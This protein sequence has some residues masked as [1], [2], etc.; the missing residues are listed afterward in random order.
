M[1]YTGTEMPT[2]ARP[3]AAWSQP[4]PRLMRR[5]RTERQ[6][7]QQ[8][9]QQRE[10]ADREIDRQPLR[11][12]LV[13][14]AVAVLERRA[15]IAPRELREITDVLFPHRLVEVV[16]A[17]D[18]LAHLRHQLL[19]GVER[20]AGR[21][22]HQRERERCDHQQGRYRRRETSQREREHQP[23]SSHRSREEC[24]SIALSAKPR[25]QGFSRWRD[26]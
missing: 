17:L 10:S 25:T 24:R 4:V 3:S 23:R 16:R 15:E 6:A 18:R 14:A 1:T 22:M 26:W 2:S 19:L 20:A 8:C 13:H 5:E 11:D 21:G 12:Q 9:Q 7:E